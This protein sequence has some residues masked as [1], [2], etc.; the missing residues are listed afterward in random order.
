[1]TEEPLTILPPAQEELE[2]PEA[3]IILKPS[4]I[5]RWE[6]TVEMCLAWIQIIA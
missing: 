5:T 4:K 6:T 1:V 3:G 2:L